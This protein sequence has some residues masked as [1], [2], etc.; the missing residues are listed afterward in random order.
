MKHIFILNPVAGKGRGKTFENIK[1]EIASACQ[2][3]NIEPIIHI[4]ENADDARYFSRNT[5]LDEK[6]HVRFYACGGDG[7]LNQ[8]ANGIFGFSNTSLGCIPIGSGNDYVKNFHNHDFLNIEK[9]L[10]G[11]TVKVD[12]IKVH[13][14]ICINIANIGFDAD[15]GYGVNT[16]RRFPFI[17]GNAAYNLSLVTRLI[18]KLGVNMR[19]RV[20]G[21]YIDNHLFLLAAFGKGSYYGGHFKALTHANLSDGMM[22]ICAVKKVSRLTIAGFSK[23]YAKGN[24]IEAL[25][26]LIE[27]RKAKS[28]QI[29]AK[30]P[31][32]VCID[33]EIFSMIN[34]TFNVIPKAINFII[35]E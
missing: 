30:N 4:T 7:T 29:F 14:R 32:K 13:E 11:N 8:V 5:C 28:V 2:K 6:D 27:Y 31:L 23:V 25:P 9:Q 24:H 34:P 26:N 35:P 16:F 1:K 20:D 17:N 3:L 22:D 10:N 18:H 19:I 12:V 15:V 21:E 33:G